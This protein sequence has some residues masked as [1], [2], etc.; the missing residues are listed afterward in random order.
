MSKLEF[1]D[2]AQQSIVSAI[3]LAKEHANVQTLPVHLALAL[4]EEPATQGT[5]N[6]F[7]SVLDKAGGDATN[8]SRALQRQLVKLPSQ[9]PP[10]EPDIAPPLHSEPQD[11]L[12]IGIS[13]HN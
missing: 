6:L 12:Y 8:L 3:E 11:S 7:K 5:Q 10:G 9:E 13:A 1:T 2:R 4:L